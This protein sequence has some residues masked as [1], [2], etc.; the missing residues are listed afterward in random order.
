M[1]IL[2]AAGGS[3]GHVFPALAVLEELHREGGH[4]LGWVGH[5]AGLEARVAQTRPWITFLPLPT[6]G[7]PR[8]RPWTWPGRLLRNGR[9]LREARRLHQAF[10]PDAVLAMGG[11]PSVAPALAAKSLGI[12]F[13]IHEQNAVLGLANRFLARFA[14]LVLLSFP[15]TEGCPPGVRTIVTGTPVRKEFTTVPEALGSELLVLG[16]S[17]GSR[18]LGD[19]LVAMG[20]E[21]A[22]LPGLRVRVVTGRAGNPKILAQ[23]LRRWGIHTEAQA[24]TEHLA[25]LL[26]QARLVLS[27]AGGSTL[28]ELA[29]AGRPAILV[30]WEHAA[31]GH[32]RKNAELL[33]QAGGCYLV[34][35]KDLG[36]VR[37][38]EVIRELW[39]DEKRL[40]RLSAVMRAQARPG[41]ARAV[42]EA[43]KCLGKERG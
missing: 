4:V 16:G 37:L 21:L 42:V 18:K 23:N 41:A 28:A 2:V 17:L 43:L 25:E 9:A 19:L 8:D 24:F 27:R 15:R 30:P 31:G 38:A 29:C 10:R 34:R 7:F 5:P 3:G 6:W 12:P 11:Y 32:Q 40:H 35:E 36:H 26:A 14:D 20:L 13:V 33:A 22:S 1:R 39:M